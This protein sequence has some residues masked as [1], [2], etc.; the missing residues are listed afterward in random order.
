[1]PSEEGE[2]KGVLDAVSLKG[3]MEFALLITEQ[4][5]AVALVGA[6]AGEG[7]LAAGLLKGG[8]LWRAEYQTDMVKVPVVVGS[9]DCENSLQHPWEW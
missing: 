4:E 7:V 3:W 6:G 5:V 2:G 1:M 9:Q 8:M